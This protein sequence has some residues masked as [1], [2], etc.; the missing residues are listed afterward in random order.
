MKRLGVA[1][2]ELDGESSKWPLNGRRLGIDKRIYKPIALSAKSPVPLASHAGMNDYGAWSHVRDIDTEHFS[3]WRTTTNDL[4]YG[5]SDVELWLN[6]DE[7]F[8]D[9]P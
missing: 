6:I 1:W 2:L 8:A 3:R 9:A 7:F 4:I 5:K